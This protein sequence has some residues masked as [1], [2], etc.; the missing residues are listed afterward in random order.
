MHESLPNVDLVLT[1]A[2]KIYIYGPLGIWAIIMTLF[3]VVLYRDVRT[4]RKRNEELI[5][6]HVIKAETANQ[7][8]Y[9]LAERLRS[10]T[11]SLIRRVR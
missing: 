7:K 3:V 11:E 9:E 2:A 8:L 5:E 4:Q 10:L 6:R 1:Q